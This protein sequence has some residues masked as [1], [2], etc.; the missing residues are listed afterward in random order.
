MELTKRVWHDE[1]SEPPKN[2]LW[3]KGGKLFKNIEGQ[4]K[5]V[6]KKD[7]GSGDGDRSGSMSMYDAWMKAFN[8]FKVPQNNDGN[9]ILTVT[10][11][12][13]AVDDDGEYENKNSDTPIP[14]TFMNDQTNR[15]R[16]YY[17]YS[18]IKFYNIKDVPDDIYE[19]IKDSSDE[20]YIAFLYD[21]EE[22]NEKANN[23][24]TA[25][26]ALII[27]SYYGQTCVTLGSSNYVKY[28]SICLINGKYY[29]RFYASMD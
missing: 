3:A 2:Y 4:W 19:Q 29:V 9:N 25:V 16:E 1:N 10:P 18:T 5:E 17:D 20:V 27:N 11:V 8:G 15:Y 12:L 6:S 22:L 13:I 23:I 28:S 24:T 7:S 21:L 14:L 26:E